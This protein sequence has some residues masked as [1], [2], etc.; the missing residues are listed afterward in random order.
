MMDSA[1]ISEMCFSSS[2]RP[3]YLQ[4]SPK[5]LSKMRATRIDIR[6]DEVEECHIALSALNPKSYRGYPANLKYILN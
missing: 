6:Q 2:M 3:N 5:M 4:R 1:M